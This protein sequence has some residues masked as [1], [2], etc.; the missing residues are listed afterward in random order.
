MAVTIDPA[1]RSPAATKSSPSPS[2]QS[3]DLDIYKFVY[4]AMLWLARTGTRFMPHWYQQRENR[5]AREGPSLFLLRC[6]H[7]QFKL[8]A[9]WLQIW[10]QEDA[11]YAEAERQKED[12]EEAEHTASRAMS[13]HL[14]AGFQVHHL[15]AR[16]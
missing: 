9:P 6:R 15:S 8:I 13:R 2:V 1:W 3:S 16:W 7:P 5:E 11:H 12:G 14:C 4:S 10:A